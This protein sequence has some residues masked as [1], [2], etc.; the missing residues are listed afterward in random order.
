MLPKA[1]L[2]A[3]PLNDATELLPYQTIT[4][5]FHAVANKE[6]DFGVVPFENSTNGSVVFSLDALCNRNGDLGNLFVIGV[7]YVRIQHCLLGNGSLDTVKK[8]LSHP[9]AFG[10]CEDFLK[11]LGKVQREDCTSTSKAVEL[12]A[13]DTSGNVAAI[14]GKAAG[15]K[16][17]TNILAEG[18]ED[19]KQNI[20]RFFVIGPKGSEYESSTGGRQKTLLRFRVDHETPGAL[21]D[22]LQ[23]FKKFALNLTSITSRPSKI[24]PWNYIF[25]VEFLGGCT[26]AIVGQALE[27]VRRYSI[28]AVVLGSFVDGEL[29]GE[30]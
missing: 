17:E 27:K 26:D 4:S 10:Q 2:T 18:I 29:Q 16:Y 23:V 12:A 14:G 8:V 22:V 28:D 30:S 20:T 5:V 11:R 19:W 25:F 3:F 1:A 7:V 24:A 13:A 15:V 21:C 9:Q 6:T